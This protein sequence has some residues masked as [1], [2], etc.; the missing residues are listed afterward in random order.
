MLLLRFEDY[1][2]RGL[3]GQI[4]KPSYEAYFLWLELTLTFVIP[5]AMLSFKKVRLSPQ[6]LVSGVDLYRAG[7]HHQ[8]AQYCAH[9][10]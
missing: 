7:I 8:P 2:H 9:R 3:L 6:W 10:L 5:I 1:F 4:I